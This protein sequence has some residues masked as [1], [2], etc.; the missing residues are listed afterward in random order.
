MFRTA[1]EPSHQQNPGVYVEYKE[2]IIKTIC[3]LD[4]LG[5]IPSSTFPYLKVKLK[6]GMDGHHHGAGHQLKMKG[7]EY[8]SMELFGYVLLEVY[9]ISTPVSIYCQ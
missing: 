2:S 1:A 3:Q 6:D 4:E 7:A 8:P 5:I 9:D